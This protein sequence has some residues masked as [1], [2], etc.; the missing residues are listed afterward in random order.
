MFVIIY[1]LLLIIFQC[2]FHTIN[3]FNNYCTSFFNTNAG[4]FIN[5]SA[6]LTGF[7]KAS[8]N[9]S[10]RSLYYTSSISGTN[11]YSAKNATITLTSTVNVKILCVSG[12]GAGGTV[13]SNNGGGQG[14]NAV[15]T[16]LT[17]NAGTYTISIDSGT[18]VSGYGLSGSNISFSGNGITF[19]CAGGG[20]GQNNHTPG[21]TANPSNGL[22]SPTTTLVASNSFYYARGSNGQSQSTFSQNGYVIIPNTVTPASVTKTTNTWYYPTGRSIGQTT[23]FLTYVNYYGISYPLV[24]DN[25]YYLPIDPNMFNDIS[26]NRT[27]YNTFF[28]LFY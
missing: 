26:S 13:G 2:S 22:T 7:A 25:Y 20:G 3:I 18:A 4:P 19:Y 27:S 10:G 28:H 23:S 11:P 5:G 15:Y 1:L 9:T 17:L 21:Y 24:Q 12:G 14:G 8:I 16:D 6:T